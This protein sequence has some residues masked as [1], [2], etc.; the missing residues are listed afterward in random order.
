[1]NEQTLTRVPLGGGAP[2]EVASGIV[3]ADWARNGEF[4]I[5]RERKGVQRL[6]FPLGRVLYQTSDI[7][8][9]LRVSP[10]AH[11]IAL[12][13]T[14]RG[15][16]SS[17]LVIL[18]GSGA[19]IHRSN[20]WD[21]MFSLAWLSDESAVSVSGVPAIQERSAPGLWNVSR[22]GKQRL[23]YRGTEPLRVHDVDSSGMLASAGLRRYEMVGR[24]PGA[25]AERDL[26]W[27]GRSFVSDLSADGRFVLFEDG[28]FAMD[29][30]FMFLGGTDGAAPVQLSEGSPASLS[31]DGRSALVMP[32][33]A[34]DGPLSALVLVPTAAGESRTMS[35]GPIDRYL[36]AFWLPDG[37]TVAILGHEKNRPARL[38]IQD[39]AHGD[40]QAL[41]PEGTV[42]RYPTVT[43]AGVV[44]G[45]LEPNAV[46][47]LYPLDGSAPQ[48]IASL[49]EGDVPLRFDATGR[50]LFVRE[51]GT[52]TV[53]GNDRAVIVRVD[54]RAAVR[55]PWL[56][57]Q[58]AERVGL[59][60]IAAIRL[61]A[62]GES[63]A[64]SYSRDVSNLVRVEGL[65]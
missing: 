8:D 37:H 6:E 22:D 53:F 28:E 24:G 56:N 59:V 39:I 33:T 17:L 44:A 19:V 3:A 10:G 58:P 38:F 16:A 51:A 31:P 35:R 47:H 46:W 45:S 52:G 61:S 60:S 5:V 29:R 12:R 48:K 32:Y 57:L 23:V 4:A 42:T 64:F 40:P 1:M 20:R 14:P 25:A 63:Y 36:D 11:Y 65:R 21:D 15:Y 30:P 13:E 49:R 54:T 18:D 7:I 50:F 34:R 27:L 2:R 43:S 55:Q 26:T 41:T 62:D 9:S